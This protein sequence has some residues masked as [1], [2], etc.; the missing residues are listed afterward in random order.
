M[1]KN[2]GNSS[3]TS[4][5]VWFRKDLRLGDNHALHA[6]AQT[7]RDIIPVYIREPADS[8]NGPLGA[9]QGWWLHHSLKSLETDLDGIGSRLVLRSGRPD[10]ALADLIDETGACDIY[11][12]RRYDPKGIAV[13]TPLK[14]QLSD[15][16]VTVKSFAGQLLHEPLRLKTGSGTPYKVY[17]PFWR[18]LEA[19]GEPDHPLDRPDKLAVPD[20]WPASDDLASWKLLPQKPDWAKSFSEVWTPG[21]AAALER[22]EAF[23]DDGLSGYKTRRDLPSVDGTSGLSPYLAMGEIS[24]ARIWHATRNLHNVPAD[25]VITFRKEL[26]W[27]DFSYHLLFHNPDL[28]RENLN[29]KYDAFAWSG[30]S[31]AFDRWTKGETGY[32][33]VDAGM[34]QLW[35]HGTMHN[36]VRMIVASFLIKDLLIDWRRGE[37]W[38]RDTLVDA[39]PA[40]NA[41]SW[42][43]VAGSGADASP[44]FR[45][46]NPILQGEKFDPDGIYVKTFVPELRDLPAKFV[47]RP[48][49]A[50]EA[51]LKT[52]GVTLGKTYPQPLV[53][54]AKARDRALA[55]YNKIKDAA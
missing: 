41:A 13:D 22:L 54:H 45:V 11:W 55:A 43:W 19:S 52:A 48:F 50:P 17:T 30:T 35:R 15:Q 25:D 37:A 51:V 39:D 4:I 33:V 23:V 28:P 12:N 14:D 53:D 31:G 36:R 44:F 34:R 21:E 7:G 47:H 9:A 6:A 32:P 18:A 20:R 10:A 38:F 46:F 26:A 5:I 24:P 29:R 49:E 40:S 8:E 1:M 3:G 16:G 27:R 2:N 42:Q